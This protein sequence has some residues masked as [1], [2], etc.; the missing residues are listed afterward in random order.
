MSNAGQ[1]A[2][3]G[4]TRGR[5]RECT[6]LVLKRGKWCDPDVL[7]VRGECGVVV[8]KDFSP[9]SRWVRAALGPR[10]ISREVRALRSLADCRAVPNLLGQLDGLAFVVEHRGGPRLSRRRPWTFSTEFVENLRAAI[11]EMHA[12]GVVHLD[13]SHRD[14]VR[15]DMQGGAV[16]VDFASAFVFDPAG[17]AHRWLLPLLARFDERA[18][19]KWQRWI[20]RPV[21]C[22][23]GGSGVDRQPSSIGAPAPYGR[24]D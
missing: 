23:G 6:I 10:A 8:V 5:L 15:A 19:R 3:A 24:L 20:E 21:H 7:L 1:T 4:I 9:R 14:N 13:L 12:H 2:V 18:L 17:I 16:L 22:D 11:R